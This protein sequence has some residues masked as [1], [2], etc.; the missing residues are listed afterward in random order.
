VRSASTA[1]PPTTRT[2]FSSAIGFLPFRA[3]IAQDWVELD[4]G[5]SVQVDRATALFATSS[6]DIATDGDGE[7][8]Q[9]RI[10]LKVSW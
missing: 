3:N 10:G 6:Y 7:A 4:T 8:W 1:P 9:G 5:V 2:L